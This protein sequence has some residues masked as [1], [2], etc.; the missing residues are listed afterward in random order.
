MHRLLP[1]GGPCGVLRVALARPAWEWWGCAPARY[2]ASCT[3]AGDR[4]QMMSVGPAGRWGLHGLCLHPRERRLAVLRGVACGCG[5]GISRGSSLPDTNLASRPSSLGHEG[6]LGPTAV[7]MVGGGF[8]V[9]RTRNA[10]RAGAPGGVSGSLCVSFALGAPGP[11]GTVVAVVPRCVPGSPRTP[12]W[13]TCCAFAWLHGCG[14]PRV[15]ATTS[16]A[17]SFHPGYRSPY[18][19]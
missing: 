1:G 5:A 15:G 18:A 9:C 6:C 10:H 2:E 13:L 7:R 11:L 17:R 12:G 8:R 16:V 3:G 19:P 4:R 14:G